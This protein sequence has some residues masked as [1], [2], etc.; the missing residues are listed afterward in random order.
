MVYTKG[1][2][3]S[4]KQEV[5]NFIFF[6]NNSNSLPSLCFPT[7]HVVLLEAWALL[8]PKV[9]SLTVTA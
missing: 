1:L 2:P 9:P 8:N 6:S 7:S 5:Y 4:K 3:I